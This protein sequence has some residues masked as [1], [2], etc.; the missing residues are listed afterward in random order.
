MSDLD[1]KRNRLE[2]IL[3]DLSGLAV[4]YSG[5][6]D[7]TLLLRTAADV[8]GRD[9][10][11][12][13]TA[14]GDLY[15]TRE[16]EEATALAA[17]IGVRQVII[18][19]DEL[20]VEGFAENPPDRCYHCKRELF[21]LVAEAAG[22]EGIETIADGANA[23]DVSDWRPG[24]RAAAELGVRSPLKEAGLAKADIRALSRGLGLP[25]WNK[26]A[27]ACLASRFPYHHRITPAALAMVAAAEEVLAGLGLAQYRVRHH[28]S[29]ARIE[30]PAADVTRLASAEV[31]EEVV[32]AFKRIGY[33][34]ITLDLQ[35]YRSGAMNE[36]LGE[37]DRSPD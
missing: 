37:A 31:R 4:A 12:A 20:G 26:P 23:D 9:H 18:Q 28:G 13:V 15:P 10:V 2:A 30:V 16:L 25:T 35:G 34:Y 19:T 36:T 3:A 8:L 17:E 1:A 7:S 32:A 27:R 33:T 11:L 5:G 21:A 6:V 29:L 24:L 14:V 22:R